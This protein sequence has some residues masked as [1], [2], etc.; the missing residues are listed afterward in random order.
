M[1]L[2][3]IVATPS[4]KLASLHDDELVRRFGLTAEDLAR[5][6]ALAF[7]RDR[8]EHLSSRVLVRTALAARL[9]TSPH[10]I[11]L[12][13]GQW[14][15]PHL[16]GS[17]ARELDFNLAHANGLL[18]LLVGPAN[19]RF[20]VDVED[21]SRP[22]DLAIAS[23]FFAP[24]EVSALEAL[25]REHRLQRFYRLW[26]AKEAYI[27]ARGMGLAI[28]LDAFAFQFDAERTSLQI[29]SGVPV[30]ESG[31]RDRGADW[32][33]HWL[34]YGAHLVAIASSPP[35]STLTTERY[36]WPLDADNSVK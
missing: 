24:S 30:L 33:L 28:P 3:L 15:R 27:K 8:I 5:G 21:T 12:A 34:E 32:S 6:R 23:D 1:Q 19:L 18:A 4:E 25:P 11:V 10:D 20:G 16:V 13:R 31:E 9:H 14:G 29:D 36:D 2:E 17:S 26:T 7:E 22:R 35:A